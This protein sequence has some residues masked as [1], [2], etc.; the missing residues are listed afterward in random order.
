M[1]SH[2]DH[3]HNHHHGHD[4]NH[5]HD[6]LHSH[7]HGASDHDKAREL[8][9]LATSFVDGFRS[10]KDKTSY[11]RVSG[12]PFA[13]EGG[14]GLTLNLVD[15]RIESNWQ[16][17]S[18]SP[19]FASKELVYMPFPGEMVQERERMVLTYVSLTERLD[20]DVMELLKEKLE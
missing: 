17:G 13:K 5:P 1:H 15:A 4:H 16:L 9:V 10:A 12:I 2:N 8:Q 20:V 18:A 6:H 3:S 19:A 14:D 7:V 11:L